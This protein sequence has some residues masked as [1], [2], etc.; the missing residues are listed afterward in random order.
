MTLIVMPVLEMNC[1]TSDKACWNFPCSWFKMCCSRA[2]SLAITGNNPENPHAQPSARDGAL[3]C[4]RAICMVWS[5]RAGGLGSERFH[6]LRAA[7]SRTHIRWGFWVSLSK[8]TYCVV[9]SKAS[10]QSYCELCSPF[11]LSFFFANL[12]FITVFKLPQSFFKSIFI[13]IHYNPE[14][15]YMCC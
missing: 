5:W 11:I 15:V 1:K 9:R 10:Q 4:I 12:L 8:Y 14:K 13:K 7:H 2:W 3:P 6:P